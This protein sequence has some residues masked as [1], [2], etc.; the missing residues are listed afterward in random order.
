MAVDYASRGS[1]AS[2][3]LCGQGPL[4]E[5]KFETITLDSK[6]ITHSDSGLIPSVKCGETLSA[7]ARYLRGVEPDL[8]FK[9]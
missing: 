5:V 7:N 1:K 6:G 3:D 2:G 9:R 4:A 8:R